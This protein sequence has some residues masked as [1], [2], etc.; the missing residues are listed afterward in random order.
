LKDAKVDILIVKHNSITLD[1]LINKE[2]IINT[3]LY[4]NNTRDETIKSYC[5]KK[6]LI[7]DYFQ[8][9]SQKKKRKSK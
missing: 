3:N 8:V 5:K 9:N 2:N 4:L 1:A 7:E 6:Y